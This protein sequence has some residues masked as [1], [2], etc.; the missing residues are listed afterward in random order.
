MRDK[1]IEKRTIVKVEGKD[2]GNR[3]QV[4]SQGVL[5]IIF[6][7]EDLRVVTVDCKALLDVL[8]DQS[9]LS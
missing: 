8:G 4:Q 2:V 5:A 6:G 1:F 3:L 7:D 9:L